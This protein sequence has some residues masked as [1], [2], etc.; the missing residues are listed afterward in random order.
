MTFAEPFFLYFLPASLL[1][2]LSLILLKIS[3]KKKVFPSIEIFENLF[4]KEAIIKRFRMKLKHIIRILLLIFLILSFSSPL[5]TSQDY[6]KEY[7]LIIDNTISMSILP[8]KIIIEQLRMNFNIKNILFGEKP[9]D[10]ENMDWSYWPVSLNDMIHKAVQNTEAENLILLSDGQKCNLPENLSDIKSI[11]EIIFAI[12]RPANNTRNIFVKNF[13]TFPQVAI[14][15]EKIDYSIEIGG[16]KKPEDLIK[17]LVNDKEIYFEQ[18]HTAINFSRFVDRETIKNGLN[19]GKI[20][21]FGDEFTNDNCYYFPII[22]I[23]RPSIYYPEDFKLIGPIVSTL[24]DSYYYTK[25]T[26]TAEIIFAESLINIKNPESILFIFPE[27]TEALL[28]DLRKISIYPDIV[29][30]N[31]TANI[32]SSY[33]VLNYI[34]DISI[35]TRLSIPYTN[36]RIQ[37]LI[38]SSNIP[39]LYK[40]NTQNHSFYLFTF[41]LK[42]N[43]SY[44]G[45]S[46]SLLL[47]INEILMNHFKDI[48]ISQPY[49]EEKHFYYNSSGIPGD[50]ELTPGVYYNKKNKKYVFFNC[51]EESELEYLTEKDIRNKIS[52]NLLK[53]T[54]IISLSIDKKIQMGHHIISFSIYLM[55]LVLILAAIE[56]FL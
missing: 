4:H 43:E 27:N 13:E 49:N 41:S 6:K 56:L 37:L 52:E 50:R 38:S 32:Y 14:S 9:Y 31:A 40:I 26:E 39:L 29:N 18:A 22:S 33:P 2:L 5:I 16:N 11:K 46:S 12:A 55:I 19:F 28:R 48:Y 8:I 20:I 10:P 1:P 15:G 23:T 30:N 35:K 25:Q 3:K 7:T 54:K 42:E 47:F 51:S 24:F 34:K 53:K 44:F 45:I 36:E 17:V 21:L